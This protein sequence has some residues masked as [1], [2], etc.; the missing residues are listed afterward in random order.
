MKINRKKMLL[1]SVA[2]MGVFFLTGCTAPTDETGKIIMIMKDTPFMETINDTGW[3]AI[4]V[5]PLAQVINY[6]NDYVGP[7][8][9]IA[10]ATIFANIVI[11]ALT[12]NSQIGMQRMQEMQPESQRIQEKYAGKTDE[13]SKMKM[14]QEMQALYSKY[15]VN[16]FSAMIGTFIQFPLIFAIFQAVQRSSVVTSGTFLG[17]KLE[18]QPWQGITNGQWQYL[19]LFAV[20]I[21][22]QVG[23]MMIPQYLAKQ[24]AKKKAAAEHRKYKETPNPMGNSMYFMMIPILLLSIVWPSG[25]IIYWTIS[26]LVNIAKT[27]IIQSIVD[28]KVN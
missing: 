9:G 26:S 16:P 23:S 10:L 4:F 2:L 1:F 20:M 24:K 11:V 8:G 25:M 5:W 18:Q 27:F 19:I 3:F 6:T 21:L 14:A 7:A 13:A 17:L 12:I 22:A 15:N 28:K